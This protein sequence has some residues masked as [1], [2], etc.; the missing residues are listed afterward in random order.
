[1]LF[2]NERQKSF[3]IKCSN[4]LASFQKHVA[5]VR[6]GG[7]DS[8]SPSPREA[9]NLPKIWKKRGKSV[10]IG[11]KEEQLGRKGK[12]QE[13]DGKDRLLCPSWQIELAK[14]A[15]P[16]LVHLTVNHY[17]LLLCFVKWALQI[18]NTLYY[19][20]KW[21]IKNLNLGSSSKVTLISVQ[22]KDG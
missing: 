21:I 5:L 7:R 9:Q 22:Q 20:C 10:K 12:N 14:L 6:T 17:F 2:S 19:K 11:E 13:L 4:K 16:L 3:Y 15:T 1:M 18:L 8:S